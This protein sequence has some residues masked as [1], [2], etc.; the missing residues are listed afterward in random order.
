[1]E[2]DSLFVL[3]ACLLP[4]LSSSKTKTT[5]A[6]GD[7]PLQDGT[8]PLLRTGYGKSRAFQARENSQDLMQRKRNQ[9]EDDLWLT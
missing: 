4:H 9:K 5:A 6:K 8:A 2:I 1:L 7:P 3:G